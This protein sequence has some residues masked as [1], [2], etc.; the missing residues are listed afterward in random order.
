MLRQQYEKETLSIMDR[1][2]ATFI[3]DKQFTNIWLAR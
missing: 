2:Y 1:C 3:A